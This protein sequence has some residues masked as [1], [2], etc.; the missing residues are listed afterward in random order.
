MTLPNQSPPII[1]KPCPPPTPRQ[2]IITLPDG[3]QMPLCEAVYRGES[4]HRDPV[5]TVR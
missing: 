4:A 1:R 2:T 5:R 3:R